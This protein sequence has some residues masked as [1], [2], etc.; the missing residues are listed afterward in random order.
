[1]KR[2]LPSLSCSPRN[3]RPLVGR[4]LANRRR[5]ACEDD[6]LQGPRRFVEPVDVQAREPI[7]GCIEELVVIHA[8]VRS[9]RPSPIERRN[10]R[11]PLPDDALESIGF[12]ARRRKDPLLQQVE[13][14]AR[15]QSEDE[16]RQGS[17]VEADAAR[18]HHHQLVVLR[19]QAD[20]HERSHQDGN[21]NDVVQKQR[22]LKVEESQEHR[23]RRVAPEQFVDEVDERGDVKDRQQRADTEDEHAQVFASEVGVEQTRRRQVQ[24]GNA[25]DHDDTRTRRRLVR[26]RVLSRR[27]GA[28]PG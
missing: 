19:Q 20:R 8:A 15:R 3:R 7:G 14:A 2:T 27:R 22:S 23:R 25:Q 21:R 17:A 10:Q 9:D 12:A 1:V 11:R 16:E 26:S 4:E 24:P 13:Q 5:I 18:A 28:A 6:A